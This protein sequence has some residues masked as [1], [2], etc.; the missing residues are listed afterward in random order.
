MAI[1]PSVKSLQTMEVGVSGPDGANRMY[2]TTGLA[3]TGLG[4]FS[5]TAAGS[6]KK[7]NYAVLIEPTLTTGQ[8]RR[9]IASASL[10]QV[11]FTDFNPGEN[12]GVRWEV[13]E[14]DADYDDESGQVELRFTLEI[15]VAG[16][17]VVSLNTVAFT[18]TTLAEV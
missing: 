15:Q 5:Q 2:I 14:V 7:E 12:D 16:S 3:L 10:A 6:T 13:E 9:A 8:F 17:A 1:Q 11:S 4:Q 18:V